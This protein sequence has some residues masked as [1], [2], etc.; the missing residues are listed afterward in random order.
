MYQIVKQKKTGW[1]CLSFTKKK[2]WDILGECF[3]LKHQVADI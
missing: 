2:Y 1:E 3:T